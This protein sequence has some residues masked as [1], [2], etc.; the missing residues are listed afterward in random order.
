VPSLNVRRVF[1]ELKRR[2]VFRVAGLY[3]VAAWAVIQVAST[4]FPIIAL[5]AWA[6]R[7]V[8]VLV[9]LGFP[10]ALALAWAFDLDVTPSVVPGLAPPDSPGPTAGFRDA[11]GVKT[12]R[13]PLMRTMT[14]ALAVALLSA[15]G[16]AAWSRS[17]G[18]RPPLASGAVA[19]FPF[20][21]RGGRS[22]YLRDGMVSLLAARLD[23]A[24]GL[25]STD[26]QALLR[27]VPGDS[28]DAVAAR[29]LATHFGAGFY[30][31]GSVVGGGGRIEI[32]ASLYQTG[33]GKAPVATATAEG[34]ADSVFGLVDRIA[35][36]LLSAWD[37]GGTEAGRT[38]AVT[39]GSLPAFKAFLDGERAMRAL[40]TA[41][42]VEAFS[43]AVSI[44]TTFALAYSRL[45]TSALWNGDLGLVVSASASAERR[46]DRLPPRYH[47]LLA[48]DAALFRNEPD[49][50]Y[51]YRAIVARSPEDAEAWYKLGEVLFHRSRNRERSRAEAREPFERA[52]ALDP[53]NEMY[54]VHLRELACIEN[55]PGDLRRLASQGVERD[56]HDPLVNGSLVALAGPASERDSV[57]RRLASADGTEFSRTVQF[58]SLC[59]PPEALS[60]LLRVADARPVGPGQD[61]SRF[62]LDMVRGRRTAAREEYAMQVSDPGADIFNRSCDMAW[63]LAPAEQRDLEKARVDLLDLGRLSALETDSVRALDEVLQQ[64]CLGR[65][66]LMLGRQHEAMLHGDALRHTTAG[67]PHARNLAALLAARL[68]V[69]ALAAA[70]RRAEALRAFDELD[71]LGLI[72]E[73][74]P[75]NVTTEDGEERWLRAELLREAGRNR[76]ALAWYRSLTEDWVHSWYLAPAELRIAQLAEERG[77]TVA[78]LGGYRRFAA[79]W[80][81]ADLPFQSAVRGAEAR[82]RALEN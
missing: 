76:E 19:V 29:G 73:I 8:L 46:S 74:N 9:L 68:H 41:A 81:D 49:V 42:A 12:A 64:Y 78:G 58:A 4:V 52:L 16:W 80:H 25:S 27:A 31:L 38:A 7:L 72:G 22:Q 56:E 82:I 11:E 70:G 50:E 48:A 24:G 57:L 10:L 55:R 3:V 36:Q 21:V 44:D 43:R 2:R 32:A 37:R 34:S 17:A 23:G 39:T 6:V 18:P 14:V 61:L 1:G 28:P 40:H 77:D 35:M 62:Q 33:G 5:P 54:L 26:P 15:G 51:R 65:I 45:A 60:V 66:E 30:V 63:P 69:Y 75:R 13:A 67:S 59:S 79:L 71:A 47:A 20:D 53:G